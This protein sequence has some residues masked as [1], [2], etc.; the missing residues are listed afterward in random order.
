MS[1]L[2]RFQWNIFKNRR[3]PGQLTR[4]YALTALGA[5]QPAGAAWVALLAARGFSLAEIGLAEGVFHLVSLLFELPSGVIAD[6]FGRKKSMLLSQAA[7]M[8][9]CLG[10]IFAAGLTGV[11]LAMVL[12][13]MSYNFASGSREALAYEALKAEKREQ[14][15]DRYAARD[16]A[17]Y[18]AGNALAILCAGAALAV[19]YR[20]AY[21]ADLLLG[22]ACLALALRLKETPLKPHPAGVRK[23]IRDCL[24]ESLRFLRQH[25][26]LLP[27]ILFN[28]AVGAVATLLRFFLQA[29]LP[30][31]GLP[32]RLL[33]PVLFGMGLG[34]VLGAWLVP[35]TRNWAFRSVALLSGFMVLL[36][37][38]LS[39][40]PMPWVM[41]LCGLTAAIFDD[42]LEVRFDAKVNA[43]VPSAQRAT[44]LS[45]ISLIFSLVMILLSPLLGMVFALA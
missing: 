43:M 13:A 16:L 20:P 14:D 6:V 22:G 44:L 39:F 45:V 25:V 17:F 26:S 2:H 9:S 35:R 41:A 7:A 15:Y 27:L 19:G 32:E 3:R 23:A 31:A 36:A 4:L 11:C 24:A 37:L 21:L 34:G 12:S 1:K 33:G 40:L 18:R 8:L 5:F 10:I 38:L 28:G 29:R 30:R 42:F